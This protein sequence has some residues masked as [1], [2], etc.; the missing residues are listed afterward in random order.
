MTL[1]HFFLL[2]YLSAMSAAAVAVNID[3]SG[4]EIPSAR[5]NDG[6]GR[7]DGFGKRADLSVI[8]GNAAGGD[9]VPPDNS[10]VSDNQHDNLVCPCWV[11]SEMLYEYD[12]TFRVL[13]Q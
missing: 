13:C 9:V 3:E 10:C 12:I 2:F 8:N 6:V 7:R 11:C 4:G 1:A 5:I